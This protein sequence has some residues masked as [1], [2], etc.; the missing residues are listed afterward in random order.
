M[1]TIVRNIYESQSPLTPFW[2]NSSQ[3]FFF[4]SECIDQFDLIEEEVAAYGLESCSEVAA[5]GGM[6]IYGFLLCKLFRRTKYNRKNRRYFQFRLLVWIVLSLFPTK[7]KCLGLP[8]KTTIYI[9]VGA[10]T[11]GWESPTDKK[12]SVLEIFFFNKGRSGFETCTNKFSVLE[13]AFNSNEIKVLFDFKCWD[14]Y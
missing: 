2:S 7:K 11:F 9:S 5:F 4:F 12:L 1:C 10:C 3:A 13:E 14:F 8:D 6:W